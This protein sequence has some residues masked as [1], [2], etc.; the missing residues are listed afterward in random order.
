[1]RQTRSQ[2]AEPAH[3][4]ASR[5]IRASADIA[6]LIAALM[7]AT[8]PATAEQRG[9]ALPLSFDAYIKA[10]DAQAGDRFGNAVDSDGDW[11][12]VGAAFAD[13]AAAPASGAAYV[14]E[15]DA[16]GQWSFDS[17]LEGSNIET[18]DWFGHAVA[19]SGDT[20]A[21]SAIQEDSSATGVGGDQQSND[22]SAAGAVYIFVRDG[23]GTWS[24]QAYLKAAAVNEN[25]EFGHRLALDGDTLVVGMPEED[26]FSSGVNG[27][28]FD[29]T[30]EDAGAAYV[31][32]RQGTSWS[33]QAYLKASNTDAD[34]RFGYSVDI[35]GDLI[36]VGAYDESSS[37]TGV[38]GDE[39]DNS[40]SG[41]G[42]AYLF[43]RNQGLWSQVAYLKASNTGFLDFF[44]FDVAIDG[45]TVVVGARGENSAATGINGDQLD[46]SAP[47]AG[48]V[49]IFD[50]LGSLWTQTAYIKASNPGAG[51]RFGEHL[52]LEDQ[53]LLVSALSEDSASAGPGGNQ[54][55]DSAEGAGA[56]Y[57]FERD[58][59]GWRQLNYFKAINTDPSDTFG[60]GTTIGDGYVVV[61]TG[62]E[63]SAATGINGNANDNS[64]DSAGA[65]YSYALVR[66][67]L[68]GSVSGLS[69]Q[70][71]V[72]ANNAGDLLSIASNG[73][74]VF[75]RPLF[76][77][78]DYLVSIDTRPDSPAQVCRVLNE[79]GSINGAD[80]DDVQVQCR[81]AR[82]IG[83]T[84]TGLVGQ[85]LVLELNGEQSLA[86]AADGSFQFP[87]PVAD[88]SNYS[89]SVQ[90]P[91]TAPAQTCLINNASGP[92][93]GGD[94]DNVEV[95]CQPPQALGGEIA[96]AS[97]VIF[98]GEDTG[99]LAA[100]LQRTVGFAGSVEVRV[101][102]IDDSASAGMDFIAIDQ[103]MTWADGE[104]QAQEIPIVLIN[105]SQA[106]GI[107][108]FGLRLTIL[109]G[110]ALPGVPQQL[111]ILIEDDET[112]LFRDRFEADLADEP[113]L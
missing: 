97:A 105:D 61:S 62:N 45:L 89:V 32:V 91:P 48:A 106:E 42:A 50:R 46:N 21:V 75:P 74:F 83:G 65:A 10:S 40:T 17:K 28:P 9:A 31:F 7:L 80:V 18:S 33:Q 37:A 60:L 43:E 2:S 71:L 102:S 16:N 15:R 5:P 76:N 63:D 100:T 93:S 27:N 92:V 47:S 30:A 95:S 39:S 24:Q 13:S 19:I 68:G 78:S 14:Y 101:Q 72:L 12:V 26:S 57:L 107:E 25:D 4:F 51:D 81:L 67:A 110:D 22:S 23:S 64:A 1:M 87:E 103:V 11:L 113:Q 69:G 35:D 36:V 94:V 70:G 58:A 55:D 108:Q 34:D 96:F 52:D 84:V 59:Q 56:A 90:T 104:S 6:L 112:G 79:S 38:N 82:R 49:Y 73:P 44:G 86:I 54:S 109:D 98:A 111:L 3:Q 85:G 99:P 66:H 77:G 29:N 8:S 41:A 20:I 88:N 53:V